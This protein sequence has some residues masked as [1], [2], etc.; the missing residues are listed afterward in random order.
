[1]RELT[2]AGSVVLLVLSGTATQAALGSTRMVLAVGA[3][4]LE[5][6]RGDAGTERTRTLRVGASTAGSAVV[7][8]VKLDMSRNS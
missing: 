8:G 1:M 2:K 6:A 3:G 5:L 4:T 7:G